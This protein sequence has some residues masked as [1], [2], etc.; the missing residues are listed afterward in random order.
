[1]LIGH[2]GLNLAAFQH[3]VRLIAKRSLKEDEISKDLYIDVNHYWEEKEKRLSLDAV[4]R[5]KEVISTGGEYI[6]PP[7]DAHNRKVIH[8]AVMS[9]NNIQSESIGSGRDRRVRL[10]KVDFS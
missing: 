2:D 7:M 6:F 4:E 10:Y 8:G 5:A 9:M 1:M 3:L